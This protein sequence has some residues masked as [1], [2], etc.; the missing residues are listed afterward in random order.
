MDTT[1]KC[2]LIATAT[3]LE[4]EGFKQFKRSLDYYGWEYDILSH[5]YIA[6]GSKMRNAYE[7]AKKTDCTHLF[8]ADAYDVL[9]LGTMQ[10]SL[11]R[12]M[13][14]DVMLFNA[15]KGCYPYPDKA[16]LY[17]KVES[18][19]PYLNGGLCF[20]SVPL[21]IEMFEANPIA[22]SD[23]DQANLTDLFLS[24]RYKLQ[25]DYDCKVFQSIAFCEPFE[26]NN[27][28]I[29]YHGNGRTDMSYIYDRLPYTFNDAIKE[30]KD[31]PES[32]K[33]IHDLFCKK[34]NERR[35]LKEYRDWIEQ[36][37]F[38]FGE[39]SFLWLW[40]LLV[41]EV[42]KEFNF[43]EIGVFRGQILGLIGL[44][45]NS[46]N[47]TG[48]SPLT[49]AGGYWEGDYE[50]DV[51]YLH[52]TFKIKQPTILKGLSTDA[53]IIKEASKKNYD[54]LYIDGGH[55]YDECRADI[56][57]YSPLVTLGGY[58]VIDDSCIKYNLPNGMFRGHQEVSDAV[59]SL[60]P[61][62]MFNEVFSVVHNRVFKRV[63]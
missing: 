48:I 15:E 4:H 36:N 26:I 47:I 27:G 40:K 5:N 24:G 18:K 53:E 33:Y 41:D 61:N 8:I 43:L 21:F 9:V 10:E 35:D 39:R 11:S 7:Y 6:Y 12:I 23:N 34:V 56:I 62:D 49:S 59:D 51:K 45:S 2:K 50:S 60:L 46:D 58:L 38:G 20:V 30:W 25:L 55:T 19:F 16:I 44:L 54:L 63:K 28:A 42:P 52:D 31:T 14:K 29:F 32:H 22:D 1:V 17:P 37:I 13:D 3:N 57:N